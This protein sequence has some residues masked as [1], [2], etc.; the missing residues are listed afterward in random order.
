METDHHCTAP[1]EEAAMRTEQYLGCRNH[2]KCPNRKVHLRR[3]AFHCPCYGLAVR[4]TAVRNCWGL[5]LIPS[6]LRGLEKKSAIP[7]AKP[8]CKKGAEIGALGVCLGL[9]EERRGMD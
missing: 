9:R 1:K 7:R 3:H 4:Q 5:L 8:Q 2:K 6:S